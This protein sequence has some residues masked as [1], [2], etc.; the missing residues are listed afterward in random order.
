LTV[1]VLIHSA[2]NF[3][4]TPITAT[5]RVICPTVIEQTVQTVWKLALNMDTHGLYSTAS[6]SDLYCSGASRTADLQ[7]GRVCHQPCTKTCHWLHLR[8]NWKRVFSGV[9]AI[10]APRYKWL[11]LL[12]YLLSL[13]VCD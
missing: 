3:I 12:T 6:S 5:G 4:N 11:Y 10:P 2:K 13:A 7:C 9:S 8:Q 1:L